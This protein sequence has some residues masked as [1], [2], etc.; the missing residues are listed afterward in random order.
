[1]LEIG[2]SM[3]NYRDIIYETDGINPIY[4]DDTTGEVWQRGKPRGSIVLPELIV[5][6]PGYNYKNS[7]TGKLY[8]ND[9]PLK[10][11]YPEEVLIP[12]RGFASTIAQRSSNLGKQIIN[13]LNS[14][15]TLF[16]NKRLRRN[17]NKGTNDILNY[18]SSPSYINRAKNII[19]S[20]PNSYMNRLAFE[21]ARNK[22][23]D[24]LNKTS[25]TIKDL[26]DIYGSYNRK[27]NIITISKSSPSVRHTAQHEATHVTD[28]I[29][30]E[31]NN[32]KLNIIPD[33][34]A[35]IIE[36][37]ITDTS[38]RDYLSELSE[39][40][41]RFLPTI[42]NMEKQSYKLNY[43][44]FNKY[45]RRNPKDHN[46]KQINDY[47]NPNDIDKGLKYILEIGTPIGVYIN[48]NSNDTR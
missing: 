16:N 44:D 15:P 39:I 45:L 17:I 40:R 3:H 25:I 23:T 12:T 36:N 1:M 28:N 6:G 5:G 47:F 2:S 33:E 27:N 43:S 42:M 38:F 46:A 31:I 22:S 26:G 8:N 21:D 19:N 32:S 13:R 20:R 48:N 29:P 24:K 10:A 9:K 7:N 4:I 37:G 35:N 11:V 14:I 34:R 18:L 30:V 41:A